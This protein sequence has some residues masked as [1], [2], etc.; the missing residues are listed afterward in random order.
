MYPLTLLL[1]MYDIQ[2]NLQK[3]SQVTVSVIFENKSSSFLK[4]MELNVLDSLNTKMMR[5][6]GASVHDGIPVPFQLPPGISNEAQ[7][8]FTVQSIVM[9][10]KLKGT[11]SFIV[12]NEEGS[13]H[14][15]LDFKLHFSCT[16]YL[17]TTP[18]YSDAFAKLL[19][20]GELNMNSIKV[21][22]ISISF[23]HLLAK[24]CFHHHFSG[25]ERTVIQRRPPPLAGAHPSETLFC[26]EQSVNQ[27][28]SP[29]TFCGQ[30]TELS[31]RERTGE[32]VGA[33]PFFK[34]LV[35]EPRGGEQGTQTLKEI[36]G[37]GEG[38]SIKIVLE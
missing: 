12:K 38:K 23:Q 13:T 34:E 3:D 6:E 18:C 28:F 25:E 24:I 31:P 11:L 4:S 1:Q 2:G 14:E 16:S 29:S 5:P 8:V 9:A 30:R 33:V 26:A 10:Q 21:D 19:E 35:I 17:I 32:S 37:G 7:F 27:R 22:G 20:S 15:K 36:T